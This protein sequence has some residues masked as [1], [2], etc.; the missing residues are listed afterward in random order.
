MA[1][2]E[3]AA[4][5]GDEVETVVSM[6]IHHAHPRATR[7]R[8]S[9]GDYGID[10][11]EPHPGDDA[12]A[13]VWQIKKFA[14][15]LTSSQK[16]QI[17]DSFRRV[18]VGLVRRDVPLADWYL[19]M[20]LDP[21]LENHFDWFQKMPDDVIAAIFNDNELALT[22]PEKQA[23]TKWRDTPGRVIEWKGLTYCE[24]LAAKFWSVPDYYL[25]GGR[26]R[27]NSAITELAKI[28]QRDITLPNS[29]THASGT[30]D[31]EPA[32]VQEHLSRLGKV[33]QGDPHFEYGFSVDPMPRELPQSEPRLVAA[34]QLI[35][36]GGMTITFRI[37]ARFADA[38]HERP[39]PIDLR[40]QAEPG[41]PEWDAIKDWQKYGTTLTTTAHVNAPLPGGLG[42]SFTN[43][44]VQISPAADAPEHIQR[45]RVIA[46][47]DSVMAELTFSVVS[48][49][50]LDGTGISVHGK[51]ASGIV[52]VDGRLNA[53]TPSGKFSFSFEEMTGRDVVDAARA[54][55]F[56]SSLAHPNRLQFAAKHGPFSYFQE[57]SDEEAPIPQF[58]ASYVISLAA[59][60]AHV[61]RPLTVPDLTEVTM[62]DARAVIRA[63]KLLDGKTLVATWTALEFTVEDASLAPDGHYQLETVEPLAPRVGGETVV[64]GAVVSR[65]LSVTLTD[66]GN[67]TIRAEPHLNDT[68]HQ[69]Y[70]PDEPVPSSDHK[71]V[72]FRAIADPEPPPEQAGD[73]VTPTV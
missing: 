35:E 36:P 49:T 57:I 1:R 48:T 50:G 55:R 58:A 66:G 16:S 23:I 56:A 32:E 52:T 40:F 71:L 2:V 6:L 7:I 63:A 51:D 31:L 65:L 70:A 12:S 42:G 68:M 11:L 21:T 15:N 45:Y 34:T 14:T 59:I 61:S 18:L 47:D 67:G 24:T 53:E 3:W 43:V 39:I 19:V 27:V 4:L 54:I 69:A 38:L 46:P 73:S 5:S 25:H 44:T 37:F 20:P 29:D 33:L 64:L 72:R 9:Q 28:I 60:Q 17:E 13:D 10:L 62:N 41:T 26:D 30:S 22:V 8:P